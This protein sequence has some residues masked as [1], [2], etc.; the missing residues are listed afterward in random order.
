[1]QNRSLHRYINLFYQFT[2]G[3]AAIDP[4]VDIC[5]DGVPRSLN[6]VSRENAIC[7]GDGCIDGMLYWCCDGKQYRKG[8]SD[9]I[10][11]SNL[12]CTDLFPTVE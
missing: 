3:P 10:D 8:S 5:C 11:V 6:G 2:A 9:G 7:C 1:M 12:E 4:N